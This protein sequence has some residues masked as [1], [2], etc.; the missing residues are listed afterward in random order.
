[1]NPSPPPRTP[2]LRAA[3]KAN[4][5]TAFH[6]AANAGSTYA[7]E[8]LLRASYRASLA[9]L[10][11]RP[12][13]VVTVQGSHNRWGETAA[14]EAHR[15][16]NTSSRELLLANER[17]FTVEDKARLAEYREDP[18]RPPPLYGRR[19]GR[20]GRA[21]KGSGSGV[22]VVGDPSRGGAKALGGG[23]AVRGPNFETMDKE[24]GGE[25][26]NEDN[27]EEEEEEEDEEP[28][29]L[30][31]WKGYVEDEAEYPSDDER[32]CDDADALAAVLRRRHNRR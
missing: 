24:V 26:E 9:P 7:L 10:G 31:E 29:V 3:T 5:S 1:M 28:E 22:G 25:G 4:G 14:H 20:R 21:A 32:I 19:K 6:Y 27:G 12:R 2:A 18:D 8:R 17:C 11:G 23:G 30:R 16:G 13:P 15:Q